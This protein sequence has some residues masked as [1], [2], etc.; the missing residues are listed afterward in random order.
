MSARLTRLSASRAVPTIRAPPT[1]HIAAP[2]FQGF[3]ADTV[4]HP[5]ITAGL[6]LGGG[7]QG[8]NAKGALKCTTGNSHL[9]V[10]YRYTYPAV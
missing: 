9:G 8:R 2:F 5:F 7:S 10:S 3:T 4:D 6:Y 1:W